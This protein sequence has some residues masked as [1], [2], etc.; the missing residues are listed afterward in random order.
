MSNRLAVYQPQRSVRTDPVGPAMPSPRGLLD[1]NFSIGKPI[2]SRP[3]AFD[4]I[5]LRCTDFLQ[6]KPAS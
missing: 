2:P 5:G 1:L 4:P 3:M 6:I